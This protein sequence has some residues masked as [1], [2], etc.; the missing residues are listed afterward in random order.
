[1]IYLGFFV[2]SSLR[3]PPLWHPVPDNSVPKSVLEQ[4]MDDV[5][6][7]HGCCGST[8]AV[9]FGVS[10]GGPLL[11]LFAATYPMRT[12]ALIMYGAYAKWIRDAEYPWR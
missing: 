7:I 6:A 10:E 2:P 3:V 12:S 5:R 8:R 11:A 1:L 9:L 4:R